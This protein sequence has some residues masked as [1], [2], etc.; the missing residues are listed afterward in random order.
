MTEEKITITLEIPNAQMALYEMEANKIGVAKENVILT[1]LLGNTTQNAEYE[2][3]LNS[4][5]E[6]HNHGIR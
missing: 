1:H 5:I 4:F 3:A 6:I 2:K